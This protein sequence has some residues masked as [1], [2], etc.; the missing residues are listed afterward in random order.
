[1]LWGPMSLA[2]SRSKL[3]NSQIKAMKAISD[4]RN[5]NISQIFKKYEILKLQDINNLELEKFM[6]KQAK[7]D[8]PLPL[9]ELFQNAGQVHQYDT[10][11]KYYANVP[12]H[13]KSAINKSFLVRGP[14]LWRTLPYEL[15]QAP[16]LKSFTRNYKKNMLSYY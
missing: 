2:G 13:H 7:G 8:L 3:H 9:L 11:V 16:S 5:S 4:S 14:A 6:Y 1:M 10:R 12:K 15:R